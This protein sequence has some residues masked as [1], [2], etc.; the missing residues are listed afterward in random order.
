MAAQQCPG[1]P[2][3]TFLGRGCEATG[4]GEGQQDTP[5][6]QVDLQFLL[7]DLGDFNVP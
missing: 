3:G 1:D 4:G 5:G 2:G 7:S 6:F